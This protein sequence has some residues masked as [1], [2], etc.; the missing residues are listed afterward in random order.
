MSTREM[1]TSYLK[2]TGA[3]YHKKEN[4]MATAKDNI[5][6]LRKLIKIE[7]QDCDAKK[8]PF[9]CEMQSTEKGYARIEEMII[10]Y[11]A[12]EAMPIGSA[13]ALIEQEMTHQQTD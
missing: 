6:E 9:V 2:G 10:R 13:I 11:V 12:K 3:M 1:V 8:W 4:D 5:K 7:L